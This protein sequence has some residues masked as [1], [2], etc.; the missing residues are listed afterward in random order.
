MSK[1]GQEPSVLPEL[2]DAASFPARPFTPAAFASTCGI[3]SAAER[4]SRMPDA[5]G[6]AD[7]AGEAV[8]FPAET[9]GSLRSCVMPNTSAVPH[10][11]TNARDSTAI[12]PI[13]VAVTLR[14][15]W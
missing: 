5:D 8:A 6:E 14:N 15:P 13:D 4:S 7:A 12:R 2:G 11:A 9:G 1:A 10:A 3:A